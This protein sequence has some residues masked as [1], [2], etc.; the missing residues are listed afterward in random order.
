MKTFHI[1]NKELEIKSGL[2][3][4][5][6]LRENIE[7]FAVKAAEEFDTFYGK[8]PTLKYFLENAETKAC[9]L[10]KKYQEET[11]RYYKTEYL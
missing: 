1:F 9:D 2:I 8:C 11:V 4:F 3:I 6:I 7:S 10:F 5:A